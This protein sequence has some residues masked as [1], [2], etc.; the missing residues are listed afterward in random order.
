[1]LLPGLLLPD[2]GMIERVDPR[3]YD[4]ITRA[5]DAQLWNDSW[6]V[7]GV[8]LLSYNTRAAASATRA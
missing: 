5:C 8:G 4:A 2:I 6:N 1:M 3:L 7:G